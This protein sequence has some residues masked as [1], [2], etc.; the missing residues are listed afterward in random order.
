MGALSVEHGTESRGADFL[1]LLEK[2]D[3]HQ[4]MGRVELERVHRSGLAFESCMY[5]S[6]RRKGV[7]GV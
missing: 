4:D 7:L 2:F 3:D 6:F 5:R 1:E